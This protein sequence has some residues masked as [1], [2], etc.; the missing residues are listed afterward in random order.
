MTNAIRRTVADGGDPRRGV[1]LD[2]GDVEVTETEARTQAAVALLVDT[3]FSMATDGRWVPMKRTALALHHLVSTRFRGDQLQLIGFGRH[4]QVM[5]IGELTALPA[6]REQGT[7][8]H[9]ALLL[10]GRHFRKHPRR[11]R[12]CWSS[13]TASRPRTCWPTASPASAYPPD[14]R[15]SRHGRRAR[16]PGAAGAQTTFFRLGDDPGLARFVDSMARRVDGRVVAPE[17]GD[18]G[19]AVVGEYLRAHFRGRPYDDADWA[20]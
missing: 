15:P 12:C 14:P 5:D 2:V 3:S 7:N 8:L 16:P 11:S 17:L 9:H 19:A 13:P 1:R 10:A 20:V 6:L 18:L 4:A